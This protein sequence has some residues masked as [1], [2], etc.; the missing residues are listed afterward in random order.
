M[1]KDKL[2]SFAEHF[3]IALGI[4][5][6]FCVIALFFFSVSRPYYNPVYALD[7]II[8]LQYDSVSFIKCSSDS[9]GLGLDCNDLVYM[10][11]VTNETELLEGQIYS[12]YNYDFNVSVAHRLAL[13]LDVDCNV[14]VFRGDNN[15]V[16]E[17]VN[18]SQIQHKIN[19]VVYK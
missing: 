12:Y 7:N 15:A 1:L 18:R 19:M 10:E 5:S 4:F 14:S 3:F 9:M 8:D 17:L 16:G 6:C 11:T 2:S 13:C